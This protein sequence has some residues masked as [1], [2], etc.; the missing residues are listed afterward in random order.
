M[1]TLIVVVT[2]VALCLMLVL[3][4][5][6]HW[7]V[8]QYLYFLRIPLLAGFILVYCWVPAVENISLGG[9]SFAS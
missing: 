1:S 2:V 4:F 6:W 5:R 8:F 3:Q 7:Y 9:G